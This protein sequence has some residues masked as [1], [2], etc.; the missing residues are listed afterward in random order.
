MIKTDHAKTAKRLINLPANYIKL[1]QLSLSGV[2]WS[3]LINWT[4]EQINSFPYWPKPW[5]Y[6]FHS[7]ITNNQMPGSKVSINVISM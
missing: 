3:D 7:I 6:Y 1:L 2:G 4:Q 5:K